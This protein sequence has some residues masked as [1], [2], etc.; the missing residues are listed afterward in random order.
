M[1]A[2]ISVLVLLGLISP[3]FCIAASVAYERIK[4]GRTAAHAVTVNLADPEVRVTVALAKKGAGSYETFKSLVTRTQ[5][6][7]AITGT[8][9]DTKTFL[10]TGDIALFGTVVHSGCIG[11]ALCIDS[12]NKASIIPLK[13]G[14][15]TRWEG[16]ETVLCAGPTL[17]A[18]GKVSI[19]LRS[20]GFR[21]SLLAPT[22][23]TAV[24]ITKAGKLL[25]VAVNRNASLHEVARLMIS[26]NVTD[27]LCLDGGS[28]TAFYHAGVYYAI[29][30]RAMTNC[31]VVYTST[32]AYDRAKTALAPASLLAKAQEK[33]HQQDTS[34]TPAISAALGYY[35]LLP[36]TAEWRR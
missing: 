21:T 31:L 34:S 23:R 8:F 30:T 29:P 10:P 20:E 9:Y 7:A 12:E 3:Q 28:S 27:A 18:G 11:S 33:K 19:A 22:R 17:V 26:K 36:P 4:M 5:P 6:V 32:Q 1:I 13:K 15:K 2:R 35:N 24:G 16:Y 25:L 14:R